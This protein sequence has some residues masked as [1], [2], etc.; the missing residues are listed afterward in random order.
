MNQLHVLYLCSS[1]FIAFLAYDMF[2]SWNPSKRNSEI[3]NQQ[4]L[5]KQDCFY[6]GKQMFNLYGSWIKDSNRTHATD[7]YTNTCEDEKMTKFAL[8]KRK[9]S[10]NC[11]WIMGHYWCG[12]ERS[13][14]MQT[15][16]YETL[17]CNLP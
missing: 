8:G 14:N 12:K 17:L 11:P 3:S 7:F 13:Q 5:Q 10:P 15:L 4:N 2:Y 6:R 1:S 9:D 16:R